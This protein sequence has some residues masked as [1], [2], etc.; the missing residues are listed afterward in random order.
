MVEKE[1][2][3]VVVFNVQHPYNTRSK[4]KISNVP[5]SSSSTPNKGKIVAPKETIIPEIEYNLIGDLKRTKANI[6]LFELLKIHSTREILPKSMILNKSREDQN[7]NLETYS[8]LE[9][10]KLCGKKTPTFLLTF[11][12]FNRNVHNFM[13][14]SG[15]SSNA[16]PLSSCKNINAS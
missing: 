9:R 2:E 10:Q 6:S 12:I 16:M 15:T 1:D 4:G 13:V 14:D 3:L 5:P 11:E 7:N 8:N